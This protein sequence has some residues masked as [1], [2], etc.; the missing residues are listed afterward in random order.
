MNSVNSEPDKA[1]A[2]K[3]R[4]RKKGSIKK[5]VSNAVFYILIIAMLLGAF[6]FATN[7]D[8]NKSIFGYRMYSVLS[9]S[10]TP[11]YPTG[12]LVVVKL[13]KPEDIKVGDDITFY[14]PGSEQE[15]WTHRVIDIL[16]N[17]GNNGICFKTQGIANTK[18]DPFIT[19]GGN[20]VGTVSF[21]VPYAGYVLEYIQN[22]ILISIVIILLTLTLIKL[23]ITLIKPTPVKPRYGKTE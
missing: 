12:S 7:G 15:I 4:T 18:E 9:G 8:S 10:M 19:L 16:D 1:E 22:N 14:N 23:I 3:N 13:T 5:I 20:V 17:Y 6:A 11:V 2:K 21:S